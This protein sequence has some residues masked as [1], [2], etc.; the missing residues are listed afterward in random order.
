MGALHFD[1]AVVIVY[2]NGLVDFIGM[3][4]ITGGQVVGTVEHCVSRIGP[5]VG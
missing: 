3:D 5:T 1:V 4:S 2:A